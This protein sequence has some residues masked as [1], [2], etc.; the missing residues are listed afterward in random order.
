MILY[1]DSSA[2]LR[3]L[4][5]QAGAIEGDDRYSNLVTSALAEL[6]CLRSMDRLRIRE[7]LDDRRVATLRESVF[8]LIDG[9]EVI[10][11]SR[12]ILSRASQPMPT[13]LGT[14]DAIHLASA[15]SWREQVGEELT[16]GTHDRAL[17]AAARASGLAVVGI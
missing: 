9:L 3:S 16:L 7:R 2:I 17:G 15:L 10:E 8:R 5:G 14:L 11:I 6:E 4:L 13:A 12:A 1:I